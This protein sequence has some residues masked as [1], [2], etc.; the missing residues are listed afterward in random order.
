MRAAVLQSLHEH[1]LAYVKHN[2]QSNLAKCSFVFLALS[3]TLS[4]LACVTLPKYAPPDT[5]SSFALSKTQTALRVNI[6]TAS[7]RELEDLPGI[8][9][10][11]AT[12]IIT[13]REHYG[14]FRREEHLM[15]VPG[16]SDRKFRAIRSMICTAGC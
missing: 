6:N 15:M 5:Q 4:Q 11:V 8:G 3:A 9:T 13:H 10:V 14:T 12:R 1:L 16:I 2:S 7:A